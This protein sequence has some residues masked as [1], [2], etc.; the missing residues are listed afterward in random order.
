MANPPTNPPTNVPL[1][2]ANADVNVVV[3]VKT[4]LITNCWLWAKR[5]GGSWEQFG[6]S[7]MP[8]AAAAGTQSHTLASVASGTEVI[9]SMDFLGPVGA[10][11][12]ATV[13]FTQGAATLAGS[14]MTLTPSATHGNAQAGQI[15]VVFT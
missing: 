9:V 15:D 7:A 13:S 4:P 8:A 3:E 6:Q 10:A 11:V 2:A 1:A 12:N 14:P 5:P